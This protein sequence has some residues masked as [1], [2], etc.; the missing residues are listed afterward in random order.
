MLSRV[1]CSE[2]EMLDRIR[3]NKKNKK[4]DFCD[5]SSYKIGVKNQIVLTKN[6]GVGIIIVKNSD[7]DEN[8][9]L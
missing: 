9:R 1:Y 8:I 4:T 6:R 3:R 5:W 2:L 7:S